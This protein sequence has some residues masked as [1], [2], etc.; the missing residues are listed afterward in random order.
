MLCWTTMARILMLLSKLYLIC[1]FLSRYRKM[2]LT[3]MLTR[4]PVMDWAKGA[5][6][7][8][9]LFISSAGIYLPTDEPPH[10]EGVI[11]LVMFEYCST[12]SAWI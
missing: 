2:I 7:K 11:Y 10:V 8:Q 9:F 4:R 6:V 3:E 12:L 5:G 1:S